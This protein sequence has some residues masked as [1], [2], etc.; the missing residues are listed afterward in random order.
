MVTLVRLAL[1]LVLTL[2]PVLMTTS[3]PAL[4]EHT[5]GLDN[6]NDD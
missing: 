6:D 2:G 5:D 1:L 3:Q 4:A